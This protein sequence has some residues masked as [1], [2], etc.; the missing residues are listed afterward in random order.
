MNRRA[1]DISMRFSQLGMTLIELMVALAISL[2]LLMG[3]IQIFIGNKLTYRVQENLSRMQEDGRNAVELLNREIRMANYRGCA[4]PKAH[5]KQNL[6]KIS[7]GFSWNLLSDSPVQGFNSTGSSS[8]SPSLDSSLTGVAPGT[9]VLAVRGPDTMNSGFVISQANSAA[10]LVVN[11]VNGNLNLN[12]ND[13][14]MVS[15]CSNVVVFQVT[16]SASVSGNPVT[17]QHGTTG[18]NPGNS[19]ANLG[20]VFAGAQLTKVSTKSY[21]IGTGS[22]GQPALFRRTPDGAQELVEG[23]ENIQILYGVDGD[24]NGTI[25]SYVD[26]ISDTSVWPSVRSIQIRLL[27]RSLD[28][29]LTPQPV[30]IAFNGSTVNGSGTVDRRLR[31]VFTT[32]IGLRN[33]LF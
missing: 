4:G 8:W 12:P 22:S 20:K 5:V 13:I 25:D 3:V 23:V 17:I 29:N 21:Y 32:T 14:V 9:D 30:A 15:D 33:Q 19:T 31:Q 27:M 10:D 24:S 11:N 16:N 26:G 2:F 1:T 7:S 28:D 18:N 6:L